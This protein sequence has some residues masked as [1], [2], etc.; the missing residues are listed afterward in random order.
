MSFPDKN[1][2]RERN[3]P[4]FYRSR[5]AHIQSILGSIRNGKD[6]ETLT[7]EITQLR[8]Y[9]IKIRKY[10]EGSSLITITIDT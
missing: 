2:E 4:K 1:I 8:K 10:T 7:E 6:I 5:A 9:V 3:T